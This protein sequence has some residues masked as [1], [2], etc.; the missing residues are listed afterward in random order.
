MRKS[1][2]VCLFRLSIAS[3]LCK[4]NESVEDLGKIYSAVEDKT[5]VAILL[6][7]SMRSIACI[8]SVF[9]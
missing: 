1:R 2:F 9:L 3:F 7:I 8:H 6:S 5:F 4:R